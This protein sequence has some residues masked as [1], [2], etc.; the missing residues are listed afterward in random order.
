[1]AEVRARTDVAFGESVPLIRSRNFI[2]CQRPGIDVIRWILPE[3]PV[4]VV[5]AVSSAMQQNLVFAGGEL[6]AVAGLLMNAG[7]SQLS[8]LVN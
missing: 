5:H 1:M 3:A 8:G 4:I 2:H 6:V 7:Q